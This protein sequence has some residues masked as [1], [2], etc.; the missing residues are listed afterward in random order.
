MKLYEQQLRDIIRRILKESGHEGPNIEE[1]DLLVEPDKLKGRA[2]SEVSAGG[3]VGVSTPL[4][5]DAQY[6]GRSRAKRRK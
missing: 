2:E 5:T 1:E 3:V 4:G 6:P